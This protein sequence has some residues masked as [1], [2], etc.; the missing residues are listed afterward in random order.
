MPLREGSAFARTI[1]PEGHG[2]C[3]GLHGWPQHCGQ[4]RVGVSFRGASSADSGLG[5][6]NDRP[7]GVMQTEA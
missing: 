4:A 6:V 3:E 7:A 1:L 2:M 5:R